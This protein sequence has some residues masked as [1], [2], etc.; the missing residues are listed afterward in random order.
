[1]QSS[2]SMLLIENYWQSVA[3]EVWKVVLNFFIFELVAGQKFLCS[4]VIGKIME[5]S[6]AALLKCCDVTWCV[7][8]REKNWNLS[9]LFFI[10]TAPIRSEVDDISL[11]IINFEDLSDPITGEPPIVV[12]EP[13]PLKLTK[14]KF[15][16]EFSMSD[17]HVFLIKWKFYRS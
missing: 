3:I 17:F 10:L 4:E 12:D 2:L 11:F 6:N 16:H 1:M 9:H 15:F 8:R 7:R 5:K 14:C 13:E